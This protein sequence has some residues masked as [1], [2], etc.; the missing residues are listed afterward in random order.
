MCVVC[1][2]VPCI[3]CSVCMMCSHVSFVLVLLTSMGPCEHHVTFT[4]RF[5]KSFGSIC[6]DEEE[7][8]EAVNCLHHQGLLVYCV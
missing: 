6:E 1:D 4:G 3:I 5:R 7:L 8:Q 2:G